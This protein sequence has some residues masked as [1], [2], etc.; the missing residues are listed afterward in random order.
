MTLTNYWWLLIWLF[1]GGAIFDNMPKRRER[2]NGE[3][4]E[5]WDMLPAIL[6]V[7]PYI[8]WAGF[9][10]D[11]FGDSLLSSKL[12]KNMSEKWLL[13]KKATFSDFIEGSFLWRNGAFFCFCPYYFD[14]GQCAYQFELTCN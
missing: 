1:L 13:F 14:T 6:M 8:L 10:H 2:L 11:Y 5:L 4:V 12:Q 7:V 9:R 3:T